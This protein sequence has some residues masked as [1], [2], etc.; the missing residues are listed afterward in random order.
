M[1]RSAS[2]QAAKSMTAG[3][4][5][6]KVGRACK[7]VP[8]W[9]MWIIIPIFVA[10][11][12]GGP[13]SISRNRRDRGGASAS[14][15]SSYIG[16]NYKTVQGGVFIE[17]INPPGSAADLAGL[18]GGDVISSVDGK[19]V[20]SKSDL[21]NLLSG[22]PVGKTIE[23]IFI[24]DGETR[25]TRLVTVSEAEND[26]LAEAFDDRTKGFLGTDGVF[27]RV[28]V[29]DTNIYGVELNKVNKN[30]PGYIAGLRDNDIVIEFGGVPIRTAEEFDAR[31]DRAIPDSTVMVVV[32]RAGVR[33]E[34]PVK[35][36]EN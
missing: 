11:M 24:R 3:L 9:M 4:D 32:M 36:G 8:P 35:M 26:R 27:K 21:D 14:A 19:P 16:S 6:W 12:I 15:Q 25:T 34:I 7:R 31:I 23:V 30:R 18:V 17:Q 2:G 20:K 33:L 22:T 10:S 29:P 28:Q 1:A 5:K 13:I